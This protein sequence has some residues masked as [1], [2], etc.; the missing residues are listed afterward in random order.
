MI[1]FCALRRI[2]G[3]LGLRHVRGGELGDISVAPSEEGERERDGES[4]SAPPSVV[5]N[6]SLGSLT[7]TEEID[8]LRLQLRSRR[9]HVLQLSV[10][11]SQ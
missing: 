4:M 10:A 3:A 1:I 5:S 6:S 2:S 11:S 9:C 7:R 8:S